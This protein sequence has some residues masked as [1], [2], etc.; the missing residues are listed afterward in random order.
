M[1]GKKRDVAGVTAEFGVPP[2]LM[3]DY[4]TLVGDTV[5]NVP[6]VEKVG[7]KTA[8]KWLTEYGNLEALVAR[9]GEIK[10]VAGE[11][12][13]KALDWLPTARV[14]LTIRTDCELDSHVPGMPNLDA[15]KVRE[16]QRDELVE[17][18]ERFGFKGLAKSMREGLGSVSNNAVRP[19]LVEGQDALRQAQR[20]R[21][22][23]EGQG[24]MFGDE[25]AP[26]RELKTDTRIALTKCG[27]RWWV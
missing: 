1:N 20:E 8:A 7:P 13:R 2:S 5:D 16:P 9:S 4:Q 23:T 26:A 14:L 25:P 6:G 3:L 12:L 18:Y 15:L 19:E 17:L 11:N 10:G 22:Q 21:S 24:D 27:P